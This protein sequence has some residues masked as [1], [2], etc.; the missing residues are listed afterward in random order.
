MIVTKSKYLGIN[1]TKLVKTLHNANQPSMKEI[2]E[3]TAKNTKSSHDG[4]GRMDV[5]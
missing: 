1:L 3:G 4:I 5:Y 2:K